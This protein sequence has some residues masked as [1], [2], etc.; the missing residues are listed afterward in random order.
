MAGIDKKGG[1]SK[2]LFNLALNN[3]SWQAL[4]PKPQ[5]L[6]PSPPKLPSNLALNNRKS[7]KLQTPNLQP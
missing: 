5:T 4:D 6:N 1:I 3:Q 2:L 7:P